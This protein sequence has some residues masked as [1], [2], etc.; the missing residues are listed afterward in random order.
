MYIYPCY[1]KFEVKVPVL[2][3]NIHASSFLNLLLAYS[4][5]R[6]KLAWFDGRLPAKQP[7]GTESG[8]SCQAS[9]MLIDGTA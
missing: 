1:S 7:V 4:L 5:T 9:K 6:W 2:I 8:G 3:V